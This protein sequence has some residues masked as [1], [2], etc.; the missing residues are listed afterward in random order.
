MFKKPAAILLLILLLFNFVGYKLLFYYAMQEAD[1][2]TEVLLDRELYND[3]DLFTIEIPLSN[4][5]QASQSEFERISGQ[6]EL[7]GTIY[8]YVKRKISNGSLIL[9]CLPDQKKTPLKSAEHEFFKMVNDLDH[10]NNNSK[11]S[12]A[13]TGI[14]KTV[15][16]EYE[17]YFSYLDIEKSQV[18]PVEYSL[19]FNSPVVL[20]P[21]IDSPEQPPDSHLI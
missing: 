12:P 7:K 1:K 13:K 18:M 15:L 2:Q 20:S 3:D 16:S 19:I 9:L 14:F 11:Q 4:P 21:V 6:I 17:Q 5:Y 8:H 10:D